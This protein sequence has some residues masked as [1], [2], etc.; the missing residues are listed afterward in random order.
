MIQRSNNDRT[1]VPA[2]T[3]GE[4]MIVRMLKTS[5]GFCYDYYIL[6]RL[7][8]YDIMRYSTA[9]ELCCHSILLVTLDFTD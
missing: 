3:V 4:K 2:V 1:N 5:L 8:I 7:N 6:P 9:G